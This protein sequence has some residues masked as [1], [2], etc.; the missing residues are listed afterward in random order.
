VTQGMDFEQED[1]V[2]PLDFN[3]I[4]WKGMM[5]NKPYPATPSKVDMRQNRQ[6]MLGRYRKLLKLAPA[7]PTKQ[8]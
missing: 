5:G 6:E 3:H 4:L 8:N 1:R 7:K 2:D